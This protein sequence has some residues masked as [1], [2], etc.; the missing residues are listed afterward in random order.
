VGA[1]SIIP[2]RGD[3]GHESGEPSS[4]SRASELTETKGTKALVELVAVRGQEQPTY[5]R[6]KSAA[7]AGMPLENRGVLH[8]PGPG[9]FIPRSSAGL[10]GATMPH[11]CNSTK[12]AEFD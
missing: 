2:R 11:G 9:A 1:T 7:I 5:E 4:K 10:S 6:L 3:G 8:P 12:T